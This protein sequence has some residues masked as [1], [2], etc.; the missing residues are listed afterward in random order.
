MSW[1]PLLNPDK[2]T[3]IYRHYLGVV[4]WTHFKHV[5]LLGHP[6]NSIQFHLFVE[7]MLNHH[8][9]YE[10]VINPMVFI[11]ISSLRTQIFHKDGLNPK[12]MAPWRKRASN[13][14]QPN[15]REL[16]APS[17]KKPSVAVTLP[18]PSNPKHKRFVCHTITS[19]VFATCFVKQ[20][21]FQYTTQKRGWSWIFLWNSRNIISVVLC[22]PC[23]PS[24][25]WRSMILTR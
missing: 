14:P 2:P 23:L 22:V 3:N 20:P 10:V 12:T 24:I 4:L 1:V 19:R 7:T 9:I 8:L 17:P 11:G 13:K 16:K 15:H 5:R 21:S 6:F 18:A 25:L